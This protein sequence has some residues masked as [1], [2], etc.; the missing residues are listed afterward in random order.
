MWFSIV[1]RWYDSA[2]ITAEQVDTFASA[3]WITAEQ[4]ATII[5]DGE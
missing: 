2:I 3:G 1:K 5:K 4:V